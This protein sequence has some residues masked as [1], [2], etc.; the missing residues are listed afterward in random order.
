MLLGCPHTF[1]RFAA[2]GSAELFCGYYQMA[3]EPLFL[4]IAETQHLLRVGRTYLY[5]LI[6]RGDIQ[7]VKMGHKALITADSVRSFAASLRDAAR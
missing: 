5:E 7:R 1:R 2:N 6:E 4:T 3:S